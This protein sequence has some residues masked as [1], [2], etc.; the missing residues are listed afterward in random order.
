MRDLPHE[1]ARMS[2]CA[3]APRREAEVLPGIP[4]ISHGFFTR[5]GGVSGGVY[6]SLNAG[7]GSGDAAENIAA[8]RA[9]MAAALGVAPDRLVT[10]YQIHSA[11]AVTASAP[12]DALAA[13]WA[14]PRADAIVT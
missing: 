13:V 5:A 10:C 8:N 9:R 12:W 6:A 14:R 3:T 2:G 7:I 1:G 11:A 4:G